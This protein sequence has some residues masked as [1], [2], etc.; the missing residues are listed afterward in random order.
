MRTRL[1]LAL[2]VVLAGC[3]GGEEAPSTASAR[4]PFGAPAPT[5]P[6]TTVTAHLPSQHRGFD[7]LD[8]DS[9][10]P[11]ARA[12][13][14]TAAT[15]TGGGGAAAATEAEGRHLDREL[16]AA[17]GSPTSCL[18][19][20]TARSLHGHLSVS[21]SATVMPTG[22]VT[23]ATASGGSLPAAVLTC[24]QTRALG[25]HLAAPVEGAPRTVSTSISF[26]VET[27]ADTTT[28]TTP[29]WHQP[30]AVQEPGTVL[31]AIGAEGRPTGALAPDST[32]PAIGAQG[33]PEGSVGPDIVTPARGGGGTIWPSNP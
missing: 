19:L 28:T 8:H 20:E 16:A 4:G 5:A 26:D 30:G 22:N 15:S 23:R 11:S 25:A 7:T 21:V 32:L 1:T 29:V 6:P 33:R 9:L 3:G 10:S 14:S 17:I 12:A 31:P 27:T 18:D 13:T 24:L 2:V